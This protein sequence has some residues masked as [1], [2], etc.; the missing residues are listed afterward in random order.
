VGPVAHQ[1]SLDGYFKEPLNVVALWISVDGD[2]LKQS[3]ETIISAI[4][5]DEI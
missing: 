4:E 1:N 2:D 3:Y 5:I